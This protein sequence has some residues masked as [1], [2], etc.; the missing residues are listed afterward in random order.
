MNRNILLIILKI[1]TEIKKV[2]V[3]EILLAYTFY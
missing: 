1:S 2:A 3:S